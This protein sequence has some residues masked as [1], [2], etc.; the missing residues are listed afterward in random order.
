MTHNRTSTPP[1]AGSDGAPAAGAA[2]GAWQ[3]LFK[4][5]EPGLLSDTQP[6]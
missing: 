1:G 2:A 3:P 5:R 6:Q 4:A